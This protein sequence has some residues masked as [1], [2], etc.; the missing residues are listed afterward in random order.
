MTSLDHFYFNK[1]TRCDLFLLSLFYI[2]SLAV[3]NWMD[4]LCFLKLSWKNTDNNKK[5]NKLKIGIELLSGFLVF[6]K[7]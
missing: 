7:E 1:Y 6:L 4:F 3:C 2:P 5:N